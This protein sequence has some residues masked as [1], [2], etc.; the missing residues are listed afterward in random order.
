MRGAPG[1]LIRMQ[2]C[3]AF[4]LMAFNANLAW[5]LLKSPREL[6]P[7]FEEASLRVQQRI[8]ASATQSQRVRARGAQP[9]P[10]KARIR[11]AHLPPTLDLRRANVSSIRARDTG[12]F[13]QVSGTVIRTGKVRH[14]MPAIVRSALTWSRARS[15][16]C[17]STRSST[18]AATRDASIG[19]LCARTSNRDT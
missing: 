7:A 3:R 13:I 12:S 1:R 14:A 17:C 11:L 9:T 5:C 6:L 16:R 10:R 8:L 19:S 4:E 2:L 15:A 18:S